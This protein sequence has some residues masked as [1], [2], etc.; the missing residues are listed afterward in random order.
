MSRK[1]TCCNL[2]AELRLTDHCQYC[3]LVGGLLLQDCA[4]QT[5]SGIGLAPGLGPAASIVPLVLPWQLQP[6]PLCQA[7]LPGAAST[8]LKLAVMPPMAAS[9]GLENCVE[10]SA[11]RAV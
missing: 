11:A 3:G 1:E 2:E 5:Q 10:G 8:S 9:R 4:G 7:K 6:A